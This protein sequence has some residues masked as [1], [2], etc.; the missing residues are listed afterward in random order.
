MPPANWRSVSLT[1]LT[2][3]GAGADRLRRQ[4]RR[5][6]ELVAAVHGLARLGMRALLVVD[7][8]ENAGPVVAELLDVIADA[9]AGSC[10][11]VLLLAR[12][13]EGWFRDL[14]HDHPLA[15]WIDPQPVVLQA[16]SAGWDPARAAQVWADAVEGFGNRAGADGIPSTRR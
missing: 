2:Q 1:D 6:P 8:A 14:T 7:Y 10:V 5:V 4:L 12:T 11:R 3:A 16:L 15:E 9:D 13:D